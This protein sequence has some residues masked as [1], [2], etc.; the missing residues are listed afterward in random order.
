L[1]LRV[2]VVNRVLRKIL[3]LRVGV[4][5]RVLRKILGLRVWMVNSDLRNILGLR[6]CVVNRVLRKILCLRVSVV[7]RVLRKILGLRVGVVNRVLRKILGLRGYKRYKNATVSSFVPPTKYFWGG[8]RSYQTRHERVCDT[9]GGGKL[10]QVSGQISSRRL[11]TRPKRTHVSII[12][13]FI[14]TIRMSGEDRIHLA[15]N[16]ESGLFL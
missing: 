14:S 12:L 6:V 11:L 4:V 16:R 5:N 3:N 15:Q 8:G 13:K 7:N 9:N 1:G 2:G 10:I